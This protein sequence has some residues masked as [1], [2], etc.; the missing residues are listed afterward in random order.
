M[1][2]KILKYTIVVLIILVL[3][4]NSVYFRKLSEVKATIVTG[5]FDV[6][7]FSQQLWEEQLPAKL[8][9]AVE[10]I[11][12]LLLLKTNKAEAFSK[13]SN[14]LHIGNARYF[15]VKATGTVTNV[16]EDEVMLRY[17]GADSTVNIQLET[18]FVYGN[19]IRDA[20]GLV[21]LNDFT[22]AADLNA[23]SEELNKQVRKNVLPPFKSAV[24]KDNVVDIVGV[25][26]MNREHVNT[27]EIEIIPLKLK[28]IQ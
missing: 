3:G 17:G 18:E 12:L 14:A 6:F 24:K 26:E 2:K 1:G 19:A 28:I 15:L 13:Y 5:Q 7:H 23:I 20:S 25:I 22:N 16:N 11:T 9:S 27:K 10:L 21:D 4:Y 8:D